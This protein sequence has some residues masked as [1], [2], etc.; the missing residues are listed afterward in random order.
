MG[1]KRVLMAAGDGC[2]GHQVDDGTVRA[3]GAGLW[4]HT[5]ADVEGGS[6]REMLATGMEV[7][8]RQPRLFGLLFPPF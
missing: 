1:T 7:H 4:G 6:P 5:G 3:P 2:H 8:L